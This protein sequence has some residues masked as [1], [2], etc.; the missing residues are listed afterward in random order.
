M[1]WRG[2]I[3][4]KPP[5]WNEQKLEAKPNL[6]TEL[7]SLSHFHHIKTAFEKKSLKYRPCSTSL[8]NE[9]SLLWQKLGGIQKPLL[10]GKNLRIRV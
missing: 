6:P 3:P 4:A 9:K 1:H 5:K 8:V 10:L 2:Y 7:F